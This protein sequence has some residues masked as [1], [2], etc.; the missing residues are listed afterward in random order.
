MERFSGSISRWRCVH[1]SNYLESP[2]TAFENLQEVQPT[3]FGA[4]AEAWQH[5]HDTRDRARPTA[6]T[7][8]QR[9]LYRLGDRAGA[10]RFQRWPG[11]PARAAARCGANS[12]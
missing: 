2:D 10:G 8:V 7:R 6:A 9:L 12:G 5:L 4:D 11:E 1:F 3:V